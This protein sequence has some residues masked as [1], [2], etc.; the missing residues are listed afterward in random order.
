VRDKKGDV[1]LL[2]CCSSVRVCHW[3][4]TA[5]RIVKPTQKPTQLETMAV[6][7]YIFNG[8]ELTS[9]PKHV[10]HSG[11]RELLLAL[12]ET[13][14][15][16]ASKASNWAS[17]LKKLG[18][19]PK[20]DWRVTRGWDPAIEPSWHHEY[21]CAFYGIKLTDNGYVE[22]IKLGA[23]G[24]GDNLPGRM[25]RG[26]PRLKHLDLSDNGSFLSLFSINFSNICGPF[27]LY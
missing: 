15:G 3:S 25:L 11:E 23:N 17:E 5:A 22:S 20:S 9:K 8:E 6:V 4:R 26:L 10:G 18:K 12:F 7:S 2:M 19:T 14:G 1:L 13:T 16:K 21:V 24:L 27:F